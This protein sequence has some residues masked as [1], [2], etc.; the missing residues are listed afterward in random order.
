MRRV[1]L[2][3]GA[4]LLVFVLVWI[5]FWAPGTTFG[6]AVDD[7][8][9]FLSTFL[10][11]ITIAGLYFVVAAGFTLI[12]GLMRV[13]NMAHGALFLLGGYFAFGAQTCFVGGTGRPCTA[14]FISTGNGGFGLISSQVSLWNW[15]FPLLIATGIVAVVGLLIQ[16]VFLRWNQGQELRQALITIAISIIA[17][18]LMLY[19]FGG[20]PEG[21]TWPTQLDTAT[22]FLRVGGF[23]YTWS[24]LFILFV[25]IGIGIG[26][27]LWLQKTRTGMVIRAGVD[28]R[29]MVSALGVKV[30]RV[31]ALAFL[32]GSALAAIG[33]VMFGSY[34]SL[35]PGVDGNWLLNSL[36]VVII[37]GMGSIWGAAVGSLLYGLIT[38][39]SAAYLPSA[40]EPYAITFTF[41]LLAVVLAVRPYGIMGRPA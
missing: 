2:A 29:Q 19:H 31:F 22:K 8:R 3:I 30:Q 9:D 5:L 37:G 13:V 21:V 25:A 11:A 36:V 7:P 32:V 39:F 18:D 26:L 41:V 10:D 14:G 17:A 1:P 15:V 34:Q 16:Q 4:G 40:Y 35:A 12:F 20:S 33:G 24:R 6:S 23:A 38:S 28:D 27:W